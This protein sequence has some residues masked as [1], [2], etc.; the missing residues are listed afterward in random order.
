MQDRDGWRLDRGGWITVSA[1]APDYVVTAPP[2]P[3]YERVPSAR[4]GY[5]WSP[6]YWEWRHGRHDWVGGRWVAERPGYVYSQPRW[7]ERDGRWYREE[8]RWDHHIPGKGRYHGMRDS[9]RDGVPNRYDRDQD[10]DGVSNRRD[11][12]RD[13]DGIRNRNDRHPDNP[14]RD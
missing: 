7:A 1:P 11:H 2:P 8:A 3:R 13:G 12:D 4:H 10:G 6:G 5:I 9:D 14:T